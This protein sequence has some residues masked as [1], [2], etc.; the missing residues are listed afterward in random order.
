[1]SENRRRQRTPWPVLGVAALLVALVAS[2]FVGAADITVWEVLTGGLTEAHRSYLVEAR[3]PRTAA[4]ALAGASL[5]VAGLLMQLLTRNRFVEPSTAGTVES[6]GLGLVVVAILAPGAPIVAKMLVAM[7]FALAGTALFLACI[8]RVAVSDSFIVPLIGIMLGSVVGAVAAFLALSRDLLQMLN[9]WML[10]DFSAVLAGRYELLW[11]V[12]VLG[13]IAYITADRFTVAGLGEDVAT[14]LGVDHRTVVALGMSI[15]AA[16]AAVVVV[17]V[18]AL[19]LL[20]LVVPNV[21]SRL[22]GD[23]A[24]RG[25]PLVALLGAVTVLVCDMVGRSLPGILAGGSTGAGEIPV[26]TLVGIIGGAVFLAM[27]LRAVRNG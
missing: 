5:A 23:D 22:V 6:A 27:M 7:V 19:P 10:A 14:G 9:A 21:V 12:A 4:A 8:R 24:R 26:G 25:L 2:V 3:L 17:T 18:G 11:L 16:V 15:V 13:V 1:M 20:G